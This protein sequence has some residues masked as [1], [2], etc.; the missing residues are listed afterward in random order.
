MKYG[1]KLAVILVIVV[2]IA[3]IGSAVRSGLAGPVENGGG[4]M[5]MPIQKAAASVANWLQGIYGYLYEYDQL[6]EENNALRAENTQLKE[7]ARDYD[8][9]KDENER[10]YR[11]LELRE[12]RS[13][14][15]FESARLV[16]WDTSNYASSFTISKGSKSGIELGDSVVTE[17]GALA[18]QVCELGDTW[19]TVRTI[20]DVEMDVG[21]YVGENSYAGMVVG[22][23]SLMQQGKT[24]MTY[25]ASGAQI[26]AGDEVLT[27]GRGGA[28]PPGLL[29]GE[30]ETVMSEAGGQTI[31]GV[32]E[33]ACELDRLTQVFVITDYDVSE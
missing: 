18:G 3:A 21:A 9:I 11:L 25:L 2:L 23:Y 14:F 19:A 5:S 29:I 24:R 10:L 12:K 7:R 26:F 22:E 27:S 32:V 28:F 13:D 31:Y 30:V 16:S 33:P 6:L 20:V 4:A 8:D 1:V 17:Y 15:V